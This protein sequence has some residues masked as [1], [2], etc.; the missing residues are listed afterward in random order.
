V[1]DEYRVDYDAGR[2]GYGNIMMAQATQRQQEQLAQMQEYEAGQEFE[3]DQ[4]LEIKLDKEVPA[5]N[6][7]FRGEDSDED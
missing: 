1:R 2:G 3:D 4:E 5:A 7:R 6:P